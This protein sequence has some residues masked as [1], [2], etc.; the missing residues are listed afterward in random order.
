[1]E[2]PMEII[3][4]PHLTEKSVGMVE[5]EN[6]LV[7]IVSENAD[8]NQIKWA[9][10]KEFD[11]NVVKVNSLI[12]TKGRKRAFVKLSEGDNAIDIATRLG[13]L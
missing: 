1:M 7:F 12:D 13:M 11:V 9:A 8:K 10:E 2:Q 4:Y 3:K 6:K 5:E